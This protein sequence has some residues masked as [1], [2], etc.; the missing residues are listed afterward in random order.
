MPPIPSEEEVA[1][2]IL[3]FRNRI[4]PRRSPFIENWPVAEMSH[5]LRSVVVDLVIGGCVE[6]LRTLPA[7]P[8]RL[9]AMA[10]Q[11]ETLNQR[12]AYPLYAEN[13]AGVVEALFAGARA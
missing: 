4:E 11:E 9:E 6:F 1:N 3:R 5:Q 10:S 2:A 13:L 8:Y 7:E 12:G